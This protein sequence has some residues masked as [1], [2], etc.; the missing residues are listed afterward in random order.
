VD[1]DDLDLDGFTDL[2][3]VA[4]CSYCTS[5]YRVLRGYSE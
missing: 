2:V 5:S 4:T 3:S 1:G